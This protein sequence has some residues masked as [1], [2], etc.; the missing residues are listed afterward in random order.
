MRLT[1]EQKLQ[2][3]AYRFY[4]GAEWQPKAGDYYTTSRADLEV[5]RVTEVRVDV[6]VTDYT[7]NSAGPFAWPAAEFLTEGFGPKRVW[8]PDWIIKTTAKEGQSDES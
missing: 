3:M 6:I 2:A 8:V 4:Q 5:Y 7:E 1:Y